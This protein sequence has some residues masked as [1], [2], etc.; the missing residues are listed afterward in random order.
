MK[1][2]ELKRL[3]LAYRGDPDAQCQAAETW[4]KLNH[5][6]SRVH[7]RLWEA[8][9]RVSASEPTF[10]GY[11]RRIDQ[12]L[13]QAE[14]RPG[15][16]RWEKPEVTEA[17]LNALRDAAVVEAG[18]LPPTVQAGLEVLD[19]ADRDLVIQVW[20]RDRAR[21]FLRAIVLTIKKEQAERVSGAETI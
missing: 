18:A 3:L 13:H 8:L 17:L 14:H 21:D 19:P 5:A 4:V 15:G 10:D 12:H 1:I 7:L 9:H 20:K 6:A 16:N 2:P 11:I